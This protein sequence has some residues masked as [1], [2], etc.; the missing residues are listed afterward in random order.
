MN[1]QQR[2]EA[3]RAYYASIAFMDAQVGKLL[4][5]LERLGQL[6]HTIIV[7]WSDH[8]YQ[9]GE[10]G[11]WMKQTLFEASARVPLLI[12]GPGVTA[13]GRACPRTAELLDLYPTLAELCNLRDTP[14]R[15]HGRSLAPLLRNPAATWNKPAITQLRRGPDEKAVM[16]YTIRT[17]R[18]RYTFW[19]EGRRG[20][21]LY[22]YRKDPR[23]LVNLSAVS[24]AARLKSDLKKQLASLLQAR[25]M[26]TGG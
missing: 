3:M 23:E 7:F 24:Q 5:A 20:E 17:E 10:H 19:D 1:E 22:D 11:Q 9:L 16:G 26:K 14:P 2:R 13:R 6:E 18:Y 25:G 12:C 8:G 21:E 15:L 4:E